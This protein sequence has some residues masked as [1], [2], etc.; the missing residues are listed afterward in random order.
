MARSAILT[1]AGDSRI[2]A[3][4]HR[5]LPPHLR[6]GNRNTQ[7]MAFGPLGKLYAVV[8]TGPRT[9]YV[10]ADA[11]GLSSGDAGEPAADLVG[12]DAGVQVRTLSAPH[13]STAAH[14]TSRSNCAAGIGRP[15]R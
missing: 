8:T 6:L 1:A 10:A 3:R 15:K 14:K 12:G 9:L 13:N 4:L 11:A 2:A 7:G 5:D